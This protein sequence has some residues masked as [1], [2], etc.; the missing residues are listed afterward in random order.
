MLS[1]S[2]EKRK[3]KTDSRGKESEG[4]GRMQVEGKNSYAELKNKIHPRATH[5]QHAENRKTQKG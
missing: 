4:Q 5:K 1:K 2:Q 3:T